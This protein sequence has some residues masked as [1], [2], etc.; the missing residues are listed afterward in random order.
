MRSSSA[1]EDPSASSLKAAFDYR[2]ILNMLMSI[3]NTG[4]GDLTPLKTPLPKVGRSESWV[5]ENG[6]LLGAPGIC[7]RLGWPHPAPHRNLAQAHICAPQA[8]S[9][10]PSLAPLALHPAP[11]AQAHPPPAHVGGREEQCGTH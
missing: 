5:G 2:T 3:V 11:A 7:G 6:L 9:D 8:R 1:A 4:A 10:P